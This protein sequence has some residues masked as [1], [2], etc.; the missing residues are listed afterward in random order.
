MGG[1]IV[2]LCPD[3]REKQPLWCAVVTGANKGIGLEICRQLASKGIL[4]VLTSR[5]KNKGLA[6]VESLRKSG[7][8]NVIFHQV[9]VTNLTT[10]SS[11]A[12]FIKAHLG[13]LDILVNNAGIL[14]AIT[15][16]AGFTALLQ[17]VNAMD[18][19]KDEPNL[20][21]VITDTYE[22]AEECLQTNYYGVKSVTKTLI[23]LLQLSDSPRIVNVSSRMGKMK[24]ISNEK[25]LEMLSDG[26]GLKEERV[27]EIVNMF[28]KDFKEDILKIKGWPAYIPAYTISKVY[29]NAYTR[30]LAREFPTFRI[31]CVSPG[32]VKSDISYNS[33][34]FTTS[35]GAEKVVKLA[36]VPNDGPSGLYFNNG[37]VTP[38]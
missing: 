16:A 1:H 17:V 35:E 8:S 7:L 25:A 15:D 24:N 5:D 33:G 2:D 10:I 6:A 3:C 11:L 13:K 36:L 4:V 30:N 29:L 9:D 18:L 14:G 31:N 32:S 27:D 26:D 37:E 19:N 22:L 34:I 38:F 20:E 28:L 23:P 12:E 21:Q